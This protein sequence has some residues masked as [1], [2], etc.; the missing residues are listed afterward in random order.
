[1]GILQFQMPEKVMMEKQGDLYARFLF[2]TLEKG[3]GITIGNAL[4]R[5]LLSSLEGYAITAIKVPGIEH[6]FSTVKGVIEDVT[7][8]ILNLKGVRLKKILDGEDKIFVSVK[9]QK[10]FTAGDIAKH[11]NA[12]QVTNPDHII[13][14]LNKA[15]QFDIELTIG[16]GRGY[17][18]SE[19]NKHYITNLGEVAI[20]SIFTPIK[21]VKYAI[22]DTRVGQKTDFEQLT[23]DVSTDGTIDPEDALKD[24]A[25]ILIRHLMLFSD[26]SIQ[27]QA[28]EPVVRK[29]VDENY[30]SMRKLLKTAL[31]DLDLSVRAYNC[32]KAADIR[33][34]GD[35]VSYN[36]ADML[37]FRNFGK[38]SLTELE[39]LVAEKGLTFGMEVVKYRL[40]EE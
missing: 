26:Q 8:I 29:D 27:I 38:K 28:E 5:V 1:M 31:A 15:T 24:A 36:I 4:R 25:N 2:R 32:L 10:V 20:D 39:E 19:D 11:T 30:I 34:L 21:N 12:F 16:K 17:V 7:E 33:T 18:P 3:Y 37:K 40:N 35:L 22:E 14:H 9:G 13:C 23:I 6:E